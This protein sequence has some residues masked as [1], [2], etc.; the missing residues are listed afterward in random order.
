V[1]RPHIPTLRDFGRV[2]SLRVVFKLRVW[3]HLAPSHATPASRPLCSRAPA[4]AS[5]EL[6]DGN[7][8]EV[9]HERSALC[10]LLFRA[11]PATDERCKR[12]LSGLQTAGYEMHKTNGGADVARVLQRFALA[13]AAAALTLT[14]RPPLC[15][16]RARRLLAQRTDP[17]APDGLQL[18]AVLHSRSPQGHHAAE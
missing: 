4:P 14:P 16:A 1:F 13:G 6:P 12:L 10:E 17:A 15:S 18:A 2:L 5:Y 9:G 11:D 7:V 8:I 3:H